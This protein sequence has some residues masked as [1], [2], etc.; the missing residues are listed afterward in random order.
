MVRTLIGIG[1]L[2]EVTLV[3]VNKDYFDVLHAEHGE[4]FIRIMVFDKIAKFHWNLIDVYGDAQSDRKAGFLAEL[5]R[6]YNDN[7][8][9]CLVGGDFNIIRKETEKNKPVSNEHWSFVFNAIIENVGLREFPLNGRKFTWAN[10]LPDPTYEKLDRVLCCPV[11]EEKYPLTIVQAF[12]REI[13]DHTPLFIDPEEHSRSEPI[14]R[15][16]N[17]WNMIEG[18]RDFIYKIWNAPY[19]EDRLER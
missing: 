11:W 7:N 19:R 8:I 13:S 15:H 4:Y 1:I 3:G 14:F 16:E 2:Q 12:A 18:F 5:A 9:P 10:N 17:Y 6:V